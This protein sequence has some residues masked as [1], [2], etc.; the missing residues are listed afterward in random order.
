MKIAFVFDTMIYGG[1]ERVGIDYIRLLNERGYEVDVYILNKKTESIIDEIPTDCTVKV[2][3]FSNFLCPEKYW[4]IAKKWWW[5]KYIFPIIYLGL[6]AAYPIIKVLK[7]INKKYDFTIAF[8]GHFNDLTFVS[9]FIG[10]KNKLGWLH[11]SLNGYILISPGYKFLYNKIKNLVVLSEDYQEEAVATNS[12][13]NCRIRKIYNPVIVQDRLLDHQKI[14]SLKKAYGDFALMVGRFSKQK[15]HFTVINAIKILKT[16]YNY[17]LKMVFVGDGQ[18]RKE[19]GKYANECGV[20]DLIF[21]EGTQ[22]DVQNYYKAANLFVHSSPSE[23]LPTVL[24]EA[25][26]FGVP[27]VAT[28]SKPGVREILGDSECGLICPIKNA[29]IMADKIYQLLMDEKLYSAVVEKGNQRIKDF[30]PEVIADQLE[31]YFR[32]IGTES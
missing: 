22:K 28:D 19:V 11:G 4:Y 14:E 23:G 1:I 15:D 8:S 27:I 26:S 13:E 18:L 12:L 16:K 17:L 25:M 7:G 30:T 5:G 24:L 2:L 9:H 21:F 10:A 31:K 32:E 29:E 3:S 20:S 6:N